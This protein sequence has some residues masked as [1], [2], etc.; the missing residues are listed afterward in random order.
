ML[1]V[2]CCVWMAIHTYTHGH[3]LSAHASS[4]CL[5][6]TVTHRAIVDS[7]IIRFCLNKILAASLVVHFISLPDSVPSTAIAHGH[8]LIRHIRSILS[9]VHKIGPTFYLYVC[10]ALLRT[11]TTHRIWILGK[12]EPNDINSFSVH[13]ENYT[14][15]VCSAVW[16]GS[17][18]SST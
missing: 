18:P 9:F 10:F 3:A 14:Y 5:S 1:C 13:T 16:C 6:I 7:I 2:L 8:I 4:N 15:H 11:Q 12:F 17:M